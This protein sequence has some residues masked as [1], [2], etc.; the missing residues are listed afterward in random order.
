MHADHGYPGNAVESA[1]S[2]T[3]VHIVII[4]IMF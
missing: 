2:A 1:T 4:T 3:A